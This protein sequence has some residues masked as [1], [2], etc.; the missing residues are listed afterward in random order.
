MQFGMCN[1]LFAVVLLSFGL[2]AHG[3]SLT[4]NDQSGKPLQ[5]VV[6]SVAASPTPAPEPAIMDQVERRFD[7]K[8]LTVPVGTSV[9]FPNSDNIRH[10]VYSFSP[11]KP[12]EIKLYSGSTVAPV[13][14]D[15]SGIVALGCNIHDQMIGYIYVFENARAFITSEN[16]T[17]DIPGDAESVTLWHPEL[18][19]VQS[20]RE[21]VALDT[22][23]TSETLTLTLN[24]AI[25]VEHEKKSRTFGSK[26]FG[27]E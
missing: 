2:G 13:E 11:T 20:K 14:F 6:V 12:F 9:S 23:K 1:F 22:S 19:I 4:I 7:P 8:V 18:D 27:S 10:H 24:A 21:T 3:K 16:G 5:Y 15:K 25:P 17:V 26:K